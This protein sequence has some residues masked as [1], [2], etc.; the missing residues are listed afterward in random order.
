[1]RF[2]DIN[3]GYIYNVLFDPVRI[4]EFNGKH[5]GLVL[6][7]NNDKNTFIVMPL[8]SAISGDGINKINIGQINSLPSSLK[9]HCTY[10][11][12]NQIRTVNANR[13]IALKEGTDVKQCPIDSPLFN[14]LLTL[15]IRELTI[16]LS[17]DQRLQ[18]LKKVYEN[19]CIISAIDM[20]YTIIKKQKKNENTEELCL[21]TKKI[22]YGINYALI[23]EPKHI[24]DGIDKIF[25]DILR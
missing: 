19:E 5:L 7:K 25:S 22:L 18:I 6:K 15:G 23:L 3:V 1:M 12:L 21:K 14:K 16:S 11:V 17:Q 8:T 9:T 4:C 24:K 10:A 13:F 20:A 2:T